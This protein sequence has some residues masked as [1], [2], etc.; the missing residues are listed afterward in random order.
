MQFLFGDRELIIKEA[1]LLTVSV[2]VIVN[3]ANV[4]LLHGGG[5]ARQIVEQGG[6]IIQEECNQFIKEHGMLDSGMV[7]PTTAGNLPYHAIVHAVGPKMGDGNEQYKIQQAI[8][9]SLKLC[10]MHEWKS[11][12]FPAISTGVFAVPIGISAQAFFRAITSYWDARID[13]D[14]E[15]IIICL[16]ENNFL[17]FLNAFREASFEHDTYDASSKKIDKIMKNNNVEAE[18]EA[19]IVNLSEE[20]ISSLD[21]DEVNNWFK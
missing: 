17:L 6:E 14:P 20:D 21:D 9:R 13:T 4:N 8:S 7:A 12:A 10:D 2:D 18:P 19:G 16:T 1:D 3:A 15:K 11:I 5:I